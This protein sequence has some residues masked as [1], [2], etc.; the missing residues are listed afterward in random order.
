M[1]VVN[2]LGSL[3]LAFVLLAGG[4]LLAAEAAAVALDR[5]L[6]IDRTGWY[7]TLTSTRLDHP[8]VRA[9]VIGATVLGL[10][11]LA[12]QLRRWSPERLA[13]QL[14]D[15]WHLQRRSVE[16][17]L[18]STA[19]DVPGVSSARAR[20]RRRGASWRPRIRAVGDPAVRP[21]VERAVRDELARLA[22]PET[23]PVE[24]ELVPERGVR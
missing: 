17:Q 8:V 13:V 21:A 16:R 11:I 5:P 9:V 19:D 15:G 4:L 1:R 14:G 7:H 12:A 22:A 24:I 6:L 23:D 18:A 20:I 2:R 3:L 10:L